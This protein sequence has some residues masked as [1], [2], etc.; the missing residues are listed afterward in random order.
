MN[1][2]LIVIVVV[3]GLIWLSI[4][5]KK[6]RRR[7]YSSNTYYN[8]GRYHQGADGDRDGDGIPDSIDPEPDS[9]DSGS[10]DDD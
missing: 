2:G 1:E 5:S 7:T 9:A 4:R 6:R 8:D 3:V 10:S